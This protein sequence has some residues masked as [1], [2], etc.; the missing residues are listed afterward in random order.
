M[1]NKTKDP[2]KII[3]LSVTNVKLACNCPRIFIFNKFFNKKP[4]PYTNLILGSLVHSVIDKSVKEIKQIRS[5]EPFL[6]SNTSNPSNHSNP[7]LNI[8]DEKKIINYVKFISYANFY[9]HLEDFP[10]KFHNI[11]EIEHNIALCWNMINQGIKTFTDLIIKALNKNPSIESITT[12]L[13]TNEQPLKIPIPQVE[14]NFILTGKIDSVWLDV[15]TNQILLID[16]KTGPLDNL[17]VDICQIALYA[18]MIYQTLNIKPVCILYY[19]RENN[20]EEKR[21]QW[22]DLESIWQILFI[23]MKNMLK[24]SQ[25][26]SNVPKTPLQ[27][28][29]HSCHLYKFCLKKYPKDPPPTRN[30]AKIYISDDDNEENPIDINED[31][32]AEFN[33]NEYSDKKERPQEKEFLNI[34]YIEDESVNCSNNINQNQT[35]LIEAN[36]NLSHLNR[37]VAIIGTPGCGKTVLS[38]II[39]EEL[40]LANKSAIIIDPQGDLCSLLLFNEK[41]PQAHQLK[42]SCSFKIFTPGSNKGYLLTLDMF[43]RPS[44]EL[45]ND[46]ESLNMLLDTISTNILNLIGIDMKKNIPSE[47]PVIESIIRNAWIRGDQLNFNR[48]ADLIENTQEIESITNGSVIPIERLL[49][50]SERGKLIQKLTALSAGTDGLLFS[51]GEPFDIDQMIK[52]S[53][54]CWIINLQSIG[55]EPSKRQLVLSWILRHLYNWM[56]THPQSEQDKLRLMF[57]IDEVADFMPP[58]PNNPPAKK[59]LMMLL[60]Q[61]RKF[62]LGIMLSTQSPGNIDYKALDNINTIFIGKIPSDQSGK[63]IESLIQP[64]LAGNVQSLSAIMSKIRVQN[65]GSFFVIHPGNLSKRFIKTRKL[66]TKHE[67][68]SLERIKTLLADI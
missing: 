27:N 59:M 7:S 35:D 64:Y 6:S 33:L 32:T 34:G 60:R 9:P 23:T 52:Q 29:C 55:T 36:L 42:N 39:I 31:A 1:S 43:E 8:I 40:I 53:P 19:L 14:Q 58:A 22:T 54:S 46:S 44:P 56:L 21:I 28:S 18:F 3:S 57:Y 47:K 24:W 17:N 50:D 68:I 11:N 38:K 41:D 25:D 15:E 16:F 61:A 26:L 45:L 4:F 20:I 10:H 48:L 2:E 49:K 65:P 37:H 66:H 62:G 63:K 30:D 51:S 5:L 12:T 13:I 67:T